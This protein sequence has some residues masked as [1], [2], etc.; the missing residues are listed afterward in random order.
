MY[1]V[2]AIMDNLRDEWKEKICHFV[3]IYGPANI[4][5]LHEEHKDEWLRL[6]FSSLYFLE[7]F[8]FS[9]RNSDTLSRG[10]YRE[11]SRLDPSLVV[12]RD[13]VVD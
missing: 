9:Y 6:D 8:I 5:K 12:G 2:Q 10:K 4:L 13:L 3:S 11:V 7:R 1:D